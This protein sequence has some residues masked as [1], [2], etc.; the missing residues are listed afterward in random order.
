[1]DTTKTFWKWISEGVKARFYYQHVKHSFLLH[2]LHILCLYLI[3]RTRNTVSWIVSDMCSS[4]S[5]IIPVRMW[6]FINIHGCKSMWTFFFMMRKVISMPIFLYI[7]I[8]FFTD[9]TKDLGLK[10]VWLY[11]LREL[12]LSSLDPF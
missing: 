7:M 2:H 6:G 10:N 5:I 8:W 4:S 9:L 11:S 12:E 1:M 3:R